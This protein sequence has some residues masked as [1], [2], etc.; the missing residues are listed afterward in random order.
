[1]GDTTMTMTM[2]RRS[3][4]LGAG[5]LAL[6]PAEVWARAAQAG[7]LVNLK[8]FMDSYVTTKKL[9]GMVIATKHANG[10]VK[11]L[12]SGTAGFDSQIPVDENSIFR[13]YSMTKPIVG[14]GVMKLIENGKLTLDTPVADIIPEFKNLQVIIDSKTMATA[15]AKTVMR[16]RHLLTHTSGLAYGIGRGP[17]AMLYNKNGITPGAREKT[18]MPGEDGPPIRSLEDM[19]QRLSKLPLDFEPGTKWE[20]SVAFDVLGLVIKRVSGLGLYEYLKKSFFDPLKMYD[21]DF[22]VAKSKVD[23][24][25]SEIAVKNGQRVTVDDRANSPFLLDRDLPSGG[26]GL[27]STAHDYIRFTSMMINEGELDGVRVLKSETVRLARSNLME[28]GILFRGFLGNGKSGFGA[29]VAVV[30]PGDEH[31]GEDPAGSFWW[32]GIAGTQ[33]WMDP[34]NKISV[35]CMLQEY[36]TVDP[37][38]REVR[39][40]AYKDLEAIKA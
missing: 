19:V 30:L 3:L 25:T 37:V 2:D 33:M 31:P 39:L 23:R 32:F 5:L 10:K 6:M 17:L 26:G 1:M 35:V 22:V 13:I 14:A 4:M 24:F 7:D 29:G 27:T 12:Y 11:Y 21:T 36:P 40:A 28:P 15:P 34:V 18:Q 9:P 20:Y 38:Q 8:T 16:I